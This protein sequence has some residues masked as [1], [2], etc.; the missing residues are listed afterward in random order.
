MAEHFV[1]FVPDGNSVDV[2]VE[3]H[4]LPVPGVPVAWALMQGTSSSQCEGEEPP[5]AVQCGM[6]FTIHIE[7]HDTYSNRS[8]AVLVTPDLTM[9]TLVGASLHASKLGYFLVAFEA[10]AEIIPA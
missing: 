5:E 10:A 2:E 9:T 6:P 3:I 1:K 4:L 8:G 7:A